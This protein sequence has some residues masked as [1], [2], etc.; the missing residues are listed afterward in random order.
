M[1]VPASTPVTT[2]LLGSIVATVIVPLVHT[3]PDTPSLN[4]V[5]NPVHTVAVPVI[6]DGEV[7]TVTT[8]VVVH[9]VGN[10][11]VIAGVPVATPVSNPVVRPIVARAPLLLLHVPPDT[12]LLSCV[13]NPAHTVVTPPIPDGDGLT[14]NIVVAVQLPTA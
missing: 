11:Y 2:P 6:A 8:V 9:P 10:V 13:V 1:V 7:F 12:P 4:W 14:V 3:P 5:V